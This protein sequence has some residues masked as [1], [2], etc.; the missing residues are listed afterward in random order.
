M[1]MLLKCL[2]LSEL[3]GNNFCED[4]FK[5]FYERLDGVEFS[6]SIG[7]LTHRSVV[8][9]LS[10]LLGRSRNNIIIRS[11]GDFS[12]ET[13]TFLQAYLS[14]V[15]GTVVE[16]RATVNTQLAV[17]LNPRKLVALNSEGHR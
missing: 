16:G 8:N 2:G 11:E 9:D 6:V 12:P 15:A 14:A 5:S 7:Y 17:A 13:R 10:I 3:L 4:F 1:R